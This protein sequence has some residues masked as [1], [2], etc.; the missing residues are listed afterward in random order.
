M[1]AVFAIVLLLGAVIT[2]NILYGLYDRIPLAFYQIGIGLVFTLCRFT[3][4]TDLIRRFSFM[5]SLRR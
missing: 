5:P 2:A 4:I 1:E 3:I